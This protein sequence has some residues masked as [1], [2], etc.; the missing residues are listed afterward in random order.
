MSELR[1][2]LA[3]SE[4]HLRQINQFLTDPNSEVINDILRVV[5][6]H[7]GPEEINRKADVARQLPSLMTRLKE[8]ASPYLADLK[9]LIEQ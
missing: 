8:S 3:I 4:D 1:Q 2:R 6:K 5:E 9:W 7:G